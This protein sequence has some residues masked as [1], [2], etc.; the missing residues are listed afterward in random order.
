[1]NNLMNVTFIKHSGFLAETENSY[2]LFDY[3]QGDLPHLDYDKDL[4]I[5]VSHIHH[6]HYSKD[7][8]KLESKCRSVRY[9]L[10]F[11]VKNGDG[12]WKKAEYVHF[13]DP[14]EKAEIGGLVVETFTSTDEGVAFLLQVDGRTIYYAGDLNW[15]Y[16]PDGSEA[17]DR[18]RREN[19]QREINCMAGQSFDCSFVVLDPRLEDRMACGMD[20]FLS[21]VK[22]R[23]V[24]PMHCWERYEIIPEFIEKYGKKYPD[25]EIVP[26]TAP[27]QRFELD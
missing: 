7:I 25:A 27:G 5:F 19:Y 11:D 23:Y 20:Y 14:H 6:D 21:K 26:I 1:M 15:W 12:A 13:M 4:Y 17:D 16:W 10:S 22:S 24:F 8:F 18:R 2:L 9:I 3:W